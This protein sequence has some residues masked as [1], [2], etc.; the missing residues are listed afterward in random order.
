[1]HIINRFLTLL[2]LTVVIVPPAT[3]ALVTLDDRNTAE[4]S[5]GHAIDSA[6]VSYRERSGYQSLKGKNEKIKMEQDN[7]LHVLTAH[8]RALRQELLDRKRVIAFIESKYSIRIGSKDQIRLLISA[9]KAR[10]S[11]MLYAQYIDQSK[12]QSEHPR[13]VVLTAV[14]HGSADRLREERVVKIQQRFLQ[15]LVAGEKALW[16]IDVIEAEREQILTQYRDAQ[17]AYDKA[18]A[19]IALSEKEMEEIKAIMAEVHDQVLKLQGELARIDARLKRKAERTLI[20][21]G[22]L[23]PKD[24]TDAP[25]VSYAP[26]FSWPVYGRVSA[27]FLNG[28]YR[29]HFGVPHHGTDIVVGENTPVA[30]AADGVVFLVREGG[31]TGYTYILI[32]HRGGYATLYGHLLATNVEG[33]QE[34]SAGQVIGMSGG[35]PGTNGAGPMTTGPHLHFEVIQAGVNIDPESVLP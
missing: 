20:E 25:A 35:R 34:V 5:L 13:D 15:D 28:D 1:M 21:K 14:F 30:S 22:L 8:K 19:L 26:Q 7:K 6:V 12:S 4:E 18:D 10:L 11:R 17:R 16:R 23:D 2:V 32:G 24:S 3:F 31:A 27:G 29:K 9:E 33:G